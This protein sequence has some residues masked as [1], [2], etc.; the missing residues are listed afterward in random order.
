MVSYDKPFLNLQ[1]QVQHLSSKGLE[2]GDV[3]AAM[4]TLHDIG[5]YRLTAYT[6][7][8]RRLLLADEKRDTEH[9]FRADEYVAGARLADGVALA[10]FDSK[11]RGFAFDGLT[12]LEL[13]LRFQLAHTLG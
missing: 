11:L 6:Y 3:D 2:C 10:E 8:M 4:K 1:S 7:P 13:A 12:H 5:Y 9:Q